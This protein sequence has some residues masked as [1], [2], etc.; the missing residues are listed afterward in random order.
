MVV[1]TVEQSQHL[2]TCK[3]GISGLEEATSKHIVDDE[4]RLKMI[5]V[6]VGNPI[7]QSPSSPNEFIALWLAR[8]HP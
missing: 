1:V 6:K 3:Q 4:G 7:T 2:I 8:L 5:K